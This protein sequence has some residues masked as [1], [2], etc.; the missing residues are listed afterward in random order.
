[1]QVQRETHRRARFLL[2]RYFYLYAATFAERTLQPTAGEGG[3]ASAK[4][5]HTAQSSGSGRT[6]LLLVANVNAKPS[7]TH[8]LG[9]TLAAHFRFVA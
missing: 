4:C 7:T 3:K 1:M 5:A 8:A 9:S 6:T 2:D